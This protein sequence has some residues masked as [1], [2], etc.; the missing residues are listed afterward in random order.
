MRRKFYFASVIIDRNIKMFFVCFLNIIQRTL[1]L[2]VGSL[3]LLF[4]T[5][6]LVFKARVDGSLACMLC[7]LQPM[8]SS[9]SPAELLAASIKQF[10]QNKKLVS[11][12]TISGTVW[13]EAGKPNLDDKEI[14]FNTRKSFVSLCKMKDLFPDIFFSRYLL[15]K[16]IRARMEL[17][18][19]KFTRVCHV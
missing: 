4:W 7:C 10:G 8:G 16:L 12:A 11:L 15:L 9:D 1:V 14:L 19:L 5:S 2:F 6:L 17:C 13:P 3:I 18:C